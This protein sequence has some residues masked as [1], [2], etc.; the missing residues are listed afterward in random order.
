[1]PKNWPQQNN[2][3]IWTYIPLPHLPSPPD[4]LINQ[5]D[6]DLTP[7]ANNTGYLQKEALVDWNGYTGPAALNVRILF[8]DDYINWL[9]QNIVEDFENASLNYVTGPPN[10]KTTAPHRD[11]TRDAVLIYNVDTGG[12][13]VKLQFWQEH[14]KPIVREPGAACGRRS[15]LELLATAAGPAN[16][17]YLTNATI[18]HSTDNMT[19]QRVNLQVSFK[20][21]HA[22]VKQMLEQYK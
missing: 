5:I 6:F 2:M 3:N 18:L 12:D 1:M 4:W 20:E 21:N 17:W 11:Y 22:F 16:C 13:D 15:D 19:R 10:I 9:K 8:N 7:E 14:G